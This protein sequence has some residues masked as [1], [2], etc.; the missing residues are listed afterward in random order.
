MK[1]EKNRVE[2]TKG[3]KGKKGTNREDGR[4]GGEEGTEE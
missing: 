2:R 1:V 3:K 4:I